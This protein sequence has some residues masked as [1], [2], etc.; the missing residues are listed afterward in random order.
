MIVLYALE[1]NVH[2][3]VAGYSVLEMPIRSNSSVVP[4][5]SSISFYITDFSGYLFYELL[6]EEHW[7]MSLIVDLSISS[8]S[9]I[10][11]CFT[12]FEVWL[13]SI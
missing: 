1:K 6:R 12:Y 9:S 5:K 2:S 13:I 8:C 7:N 4:L 11:F 3:S 10:T